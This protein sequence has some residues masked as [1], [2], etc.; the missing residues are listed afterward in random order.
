M[1]NRVPARLLALGVLGVVAWTGA[2]CASPGTG[3]GAPAPTPTGSG[4]TCQPS[5]TA[6]TLTLTETDSGRAVCARVSQRIEIFLHGS[7][8]SKWAPITATGTAL[9][10]ATSGKLSLAI[11]VTGA[12]FAAVAPGVAEVGSTRP[13]CDTRQAGT[14]CPTTAGFHLT[15]TV[16]AS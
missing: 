6:T 5:S 16:V 12:A 14:E 9:A 11:G 15:V 10:P 7:A 2:G 13:M 8:Q 1:R 3:V 4:T